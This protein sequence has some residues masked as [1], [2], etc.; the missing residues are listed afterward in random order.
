MST[1]SK[2]G[3]VIKLPSPTPPTIQTIELVH[4]TKPT[5]VLHPSLRQRLDNLPANVNIEDVRVV[6]K[7]KASAATNAMVLQLHDSM[8]A[9]N[10]LSNST[11]TPKSKVSS[12]TPKKNAAPPPQGKVL[13]P[14]T[15]RYIDANGALAKKLGLAP[16]NPRPDPRPDPSDDRLKGSVIIF[17]GF[18]DANLKKMIEARGGIV[19]DNWVNNV[20]LVIAKDPAANSEKIMKARAAN[21]PVIHVDYAIAVLGL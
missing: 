2:R 21:I 1:P 4:P 17:T 11:T 3:S 16:T 15:G 8:N 12:K 9:L 6:I 10:T 20:E 14:A 5:L 7:A 13:N 18:R 19:T